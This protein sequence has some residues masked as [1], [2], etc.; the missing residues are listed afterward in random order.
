[1]CCACA[2]SDRDLYDAGTAQTRARV[3]ERTMATRAAY[4]SS[5]GAELAVAVARRTH[6]E[7][8]STAPRGCSSRKRESAISLS[9][10]RTWPG[11]PAPGGRGAAGCWG[12]AGFSL[13]SHSH[14]TELARHGPRERSCA[15][16]AARSHSPRGRALTAESRVPAGS[17]SCS[18]AA[19]C[20]LGPWTRGTPRREDR[21]A[22]GRLA[23][24]RL[25]LHGSLPGEKSY[26]EMRRTRR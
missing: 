23:S 20:F 24:K 26:H 25:L 12:G 18:R 16:N 1:M 11:A 21:A 19:S 14:V 2:L 3:R 10:S 17:W 9:K 22:G 4:N 5:V 15:R 8:S 6:Q 7:R 13:F